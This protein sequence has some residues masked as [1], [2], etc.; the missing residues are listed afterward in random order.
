VADERRIVRDVLELWQSRSW[1]DTAGAASIV[2]DSIQAGDSPREAAKRAPLNFIAMN[3]IG[4]ATLEEALQ[5][6]SGPSP[7]SLASVSP[8]TI[9]FAAAGP[10]DEIQLRLG[11]EFRDIAIAVRASTGRDR[12]RLESA[13]ALRP[14]DIID[15]LNRESPTILHVSGHGGPSGVAMEDDNGYAVDVSTD[16]IVR[17][18]SVA[19]PNLRLVVFNCCESSFQAKP[20]IAHVDLAIGMTD[21]IGDEAARLFSEQLYSSLAEAV[22]VGRAFEQAKLRI[23]LEGIPEDQIPVLY[24][25]PEVD[26]GTVVLLP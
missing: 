25:K 16:Q 10:S 18:V 24:S 11:A 22:P 19:G 1:T 15:A 5:G 14:K 9:L 23:N 12:I 2:A 4:R 8:M 3:G 21:S 26:P 7:S 6:I 13:P 20:A 17:L